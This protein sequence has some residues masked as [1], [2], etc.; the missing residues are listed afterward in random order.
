MAIV[1]RYQPGQI[2]ERP[3]FQ[4]RLTTRASAED[5]GMAVARGM[6]ALS[7]GVGQ[8]SDAMVAIKGLEDE[9]IA[10]ERDNQFAAQ[11]RELQYGENGYL[12]LQGAT[13]VQAREAYERNLDELRRRNGEGLTP[14]QSRMYTDAS[15]ARV[16]SALDASIVHA[17]RERRTWFADASTARID[18][19]AEDALAG[20]QNPAVVRRN[21]AAGQA[22]LRSMA[23]LQGWDQDTLANREAEFI[24]GVHKN[25]TLRMMQSD[26]LAADRYRRENMSSLTGPHQYDLDVA[27]APAVREAE[28]VRITEEILSG[29]RA[30]G[31]GGGRAPS[32]PTIGQTGP[33]QARA[34]LTERAVG[35]G[36]RSD[37]IDNLDA[38]FATNLAALMQDAPENIRAGLGITSGYRSADTQ[39]GI[40][41][42]H[43]PRYGFSAADIASFRSDVASMGAA[44]AGERWR[45]R[46]Q[47][48]GMTRMIAPPGGSFHQSGQAVDLSWNG[49][50]FVNAPPEV[51]AWVHQNA[52]RYGM[53][54]PMGHEPW[55]IEPIGTR[56]TGGGTGGGTVAAR[57]GSVSPRTML[58][59]PDQIEAQL[60][61]ITDP[62]TRDLVRRRLNAN[63]EAQIRA[64]DQAERA[65][66]AELWSVIE[67]GGTP[68]QA[69]QDVRN[70]AGMSAV[71]SAWSYVEAV[72]QRG[73]PTDDDILVY[74][75]RRF[76]ATNP[77]EFSQLDLNDYRTRL[78]PDTFREMTALQTGALTNQ[79]QAASEGLA[80]TTAFS[81]ATGALEAV[82]ITT[83][84]LDGTRREEAARRI[85]MFNN[86]LAQQMAE[87]KEAN[88]GR[89][90]NQMDI[91]QMINQMLLPVVVS[92]PRGGT[93]LMDSILG[94][95]TTTVPMFEAGGIGNL[96]GD[97][98]GSVGV[99]YA[100]IP[101]AD[102]VEI[103]VQLQNVLGR[104]PSEA[105]VV[106]A[107]NTYLTS[108]IT[109][110]EPPIPLTTSALPPLYHQLTPDQRD[111]MDLIRG[112]RPASPLAN[113]SV[114][115]SAAEPAGSL[116]IYDEDE[117][118]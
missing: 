85:A 70:L 100:R 44:A 71:S 55:H 6:G 23:A 61:G 90:P 106:Q 18:T 47:A 113:F 33:T 12:T 5:A 11:L 45:S 109:P 26:P 48:S 4:Q 93:G 76:A 72:A 24:S 84:G 21:I 42:N 16:N 117:Q 115:M 27:L 75:M 66:R 31:G 114:D 29:G 15:T 8:L 43:M 1:P 65:A 101:P 40:V 81:Q 99:T 104:R 68:D 102:R 60:A 51:R 53:H 34:F 111:Q 58:P 87:F 14:A 77:D 63:V 88:N 95:S 57:T 116:L 7:Q 59:S 10:K 50:A 32:G 28:A 97:R 35:G 94:P 74:D 64:A 96:G 73:R 110:P 3:I 19:F 54:F 78:S 62:Q 52:G 98:P 36:R 46:L 92:Q 9:A 13:A 82:G 37:A 103:E 20:F 2:A 112:R 69:S 41:V 30:A 22:E 108:S 56:G 67:A 80:L 89:N 79:R 118:P 83:N 86:M 49:G 105:E 25:V 38:S 107:Y 17:A 91:Q 39:A